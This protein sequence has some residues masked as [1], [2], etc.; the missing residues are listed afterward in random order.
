VLCG[1]IYLAGLVYL[2]SCLVVFW[3]CVLVGV[4]LEGLGV[5]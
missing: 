3:T 5:L 4:P 1:A 2:G